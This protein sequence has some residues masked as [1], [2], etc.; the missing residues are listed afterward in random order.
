MGEVKPRIG[1][2]GVGVMGQCGHLRNYASIHDCEVVA[3]AEVRPELGRKVA[4]RYGVPGVYTSAAEMIEKEKLHGIVATQPFE[5]YGSIVPELYQAGIPILTEKP[6][7]SSLE[8]GAKFLSCL[9]DSKS[10]H[11]VGYQKRCDPATIT[12]KAEIDRLK[13]TG[14]LGPL[15]YVRVTIPFG[16]WIAAGFDDVITT[17]EV[18]AGLPKDP[19]ATDMDAATYEQFVWFITFYNHQANLLRHILGEA[20]DIK[21]VSN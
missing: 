12:A 21:Y 7:A 2:V 15:K 8:T 19:P 9:K 11:M 6:F 5:L 18:I 13:E 20:Y 1:F 10:W 17:D 14:E 4:Q 3:L 16:D